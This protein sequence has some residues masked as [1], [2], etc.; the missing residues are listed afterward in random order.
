[1]PNKKT[2]VTVGTIV[3][4]GHAAYKAWG[5]EP[6]QIFLEALGGA[7]GGYVGG[8]VPDIIDPPTSP[9]HRSIGHG[10]IPNGIVSAI[11]Y[12][13]LG[14][15][16]NSLRSRAADYQSKREQAEGLVDQIKY[17]LLEALCY[18]LSGFLAGLGAGHTSHLLLDLTTPS[19][20]PWFA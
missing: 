18:I 3:G 10:V 7:L 13:N 17:G 4:G 2:H 1:M 5:Q 19:R 11:C 16:Q 8:R 15:W 12:K 20:L 6:Y 14:N 9:R